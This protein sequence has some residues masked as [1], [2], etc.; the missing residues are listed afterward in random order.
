MW[1]SLSSQTHTMFLTI[2]LQ[3]IC[4]SSDYRIPSES[5]SSDVFEVGASCYG[6]S[7]L[8]SR[9]H[10]SQRY[11][12]ERIEKSTMVHRMEC[13][14]RNR[15][16]WLGFPSGLYHPWSEGNYWTTSR[17]SPGTGIHDIRFQNC[18]LNDQIIMIQSSISM[19]F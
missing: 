18:I 15:I 9:I 10:F 14:F 4:Y 5:Y 7:F 19:S 16:F 3:K 2:F 12:N 8:H 13:F 6:V 11:R 17:C 1:F